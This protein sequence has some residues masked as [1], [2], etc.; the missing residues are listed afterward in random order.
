M[1]KI[2]YPD[3]PVDL[4]DKTITLVARLILLLI[5]AQHSMLRQ[6]SSEI[7][8]LRR[9]LGNSFLGAWPDSIAGRWG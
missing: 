8:D 3:L 9:K 2:P 5:H 1:N 4:R 6:S 7:Y